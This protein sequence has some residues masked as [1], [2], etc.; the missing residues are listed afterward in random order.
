MTALPKS[1]SDLRGARKMVAREAGASTVAAFFEANKDAIRAVLPAHLTPDRMV[2]V[3]LRCLRTTPKL[4]GATIESLFG[5]V[6]TCAQLGLEPNTPQGLVF[7][8]PFENKKKGIIE[9]QVIIG[10]KGLI[11]LARRSGEIV[12]ISSHAVC[13][14]DPFE[15]V[16]GTEERID[17]RP[18]LDGDRGDVTGF[19]AVAKLKGGGTQLEFMTAHEVNKIRDGSQGYKTARHFKN[20]NTPWITAY[21]EMGRKTV[22]RRLCKYLPMSIELAN[23]VALEG[24]AERNETQALD[25][26]LDGDFTILAEDAPASGADTVDPETAEADAGRVGQIEQKTEL[27][28]DIGETRQTEAVR[29]E[30]KTTATASASAD[31]QD[32]SAARPARTASPTANDDGFGDPE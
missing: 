3:A 22:I 19:Y 12:S 18:Y 8:I 9:V 27:P 1:I 15:V 2:K 30:R 16:F 29:T 28:I 25:S 6:I 24:L 17:H 5:A 21:E 26:V 4:L 20:D 23:A 14:G 31:R 13:R 7:L 32:V 11:D 10:Y